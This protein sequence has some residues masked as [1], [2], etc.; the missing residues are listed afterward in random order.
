MSIGY[1][2]DSVSKRFTVITKV[3]II[4]LYADKDS[5]R[6]K[7]DMKQYRSAA[8]ACGKIRLL[9]EKIRFLY[10]LDT[11]RF[12]YYYLSLRIFHPCLFFDNYQSLAADLPGPVNN[13]RTDTDIT[14]K[15]RIVTD[16]E[17]G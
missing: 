11:D 6:T 7:Q 15:I 16:H 1:T 13:T 12:E 10:Q 9:T 8:N 14:D 17:D 5:N 4:Q 2:G 3:F